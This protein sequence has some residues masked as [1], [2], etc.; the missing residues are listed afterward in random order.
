M[1]INE[2]TGEDVT[3]PL[4]Q[5]PEYWECGHLVASLDRT[6][7]ECDGGE[8]FDREHEFREVVEM[9]FRAHFK[10]GSTSSNLPSGALRELWETLSPQ[11]F[12]EA[13][14][15]DGLELDGFVFQRVLIEALEDAGVIEPKG[16]LCDPGGPGMTSSVSLLFAKRPQD[17]IKKALA[18]LRLQLA[19]D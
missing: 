19:V 6:F 16:Q 7:C 1:T 17:C 11:S 12:E 8:L 3:C 14:E 2:D 4:C 5:S 9:A 18:L 13:V 10:A 15:G